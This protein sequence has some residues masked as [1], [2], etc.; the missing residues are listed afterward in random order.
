MMLGE[1]AGA[2]QVAPHRVGAVSLEE[3]ILLHLIVE[4]SHGSPPGWIKRTMGGNYTQ[5]SGD[6]IEKVS[7]GKA[8]G[9]G[10]VN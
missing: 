1:M 4:L 8:T 9:V 6:T 5:L 2:A 7:S 3:Q 10:E